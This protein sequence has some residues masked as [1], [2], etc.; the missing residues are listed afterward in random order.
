MTDV[1]FPSGSFEEYEEVEVD[2]LYGMDRLNIN[3][4]D[5]DGDGPENKVSACS[6]NLGVYNFDSEDGEMSREIFKG[7]GIKNE[8][9][10]SVTETERTVNENERESQLRTPPKRPFL[11][12]GEGKSLVISNSRK[13]NGDSTTRRSSQ[14]RQHTAAKTVSNSAPARRFVRS[15]KPVMPEVGRNGKLDSLL[16]GIESSNLTT[17]SG[18]ERFEIFDTEEEFMG[19]KW[20]KEQNMDS[21]KSYRSEKIKGNTAEREQEKDYD[22]L[23][24]Q[25]LDLLDEKMEYIHETHEEMLKKKTLL[26]RERKLLESHKVNFEKELRAKFEK[27]RQEIELEKRRLERENNKLTKDKITLNDQVTRLK[28]TIKSKDAEINRLTKEITLMERK[29]KERENMQNRVPL[30]RKE[31]SSESVEK[32][33]IG[34]PRSG[35]QNIG[36]FERPRLTGST[37]ITPL[38]TN[39]QTTTSISSNSSASFIDRDLVIEEQLASFDFE[40]ELDLLY[41]ILSTC[42][43]FVGEEEDFT[44]LPGIPE[45]VGRPWCDIEKPYKIQ[46]DDDLR[47]ITFKFPSGLVEI[48]FCDEQGDA[49]CPRNTRKLLW[50]HLGWCILVY[51]NRDIKAIKPDKNITYHYVEKDIVKCVVGTSDLLNYDGETTKLHFS[52]FFSLG[53]LQCVDPETRKTYII[54][55]DMSKQILNG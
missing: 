35:N 3:S 49:V 12:K 27:S 14:I 47:T 23:I 51:P 50:T 6:T 11:R 33:R 22:K 46:R 20:D 54:H 30:G 25:K 2:N 28:M 32:K 43:E 26:D 19:I 5:I 21:Q 44:T 15:N 34:K 41:G 38:T 7:Y 13:A 18:A 36:E 37:S 17:E 31:V 42:F 9:D 55:S 29:E 8:T 45:E 4:E 48:V 10:G 16:L 40:K 1:H 53:Q 39:L 52:K 24:Q